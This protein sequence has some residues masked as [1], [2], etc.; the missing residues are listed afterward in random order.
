MNKCAALILFFLSAFAMAEKTAKVPLTYATDNQNDIVLRGQ[1]QTVSVPISI[2]DGQEVDS[3]RLSLSIY[4][5]NVIDKSMLWIS[6]GNRTL[7]NVEIK[8][9]AQHQL[10]EMTI[11][12]ELLSKREPRL[13]LR[14]QHLSNDPSLVIDTTRLKTII[15]AERSSYTLNYQES[16]QVS[17]AT[18]S[19]FDEM[20]RSGQH[21]DAPVHLVSVLKND[22]EAA[23]NIAAS[24]V[25][26][27]TLK[28]GSKEYHFDYRQFSEYNAALEGPAIVF[29]T[30]DDL[31][32]AGW[33]G[34]E[35]YQQIVGP[36]LGM[37]DTAKTSEWVLFLSGVSERDV[38][39]ATKVFA[40]NVRRLPERDH[41][42]VTE[43]DD[44]ID[45]SLKS[46]S[47]YLLSE[48]TDQ[49]DLT[50][51]P[52]E[53]S[54]VMP[55]NI[56]FSSE[57][58]AKINLLLTHSRVA[59]GAGS[60]ILRVNGDYANSLPLRS[61][62]WRDSQHYRLNIPMRDFRPGINKVT[63]EVYGPVDVRNQQ[64]RFAVYMSEKSNLKLSSWV[65][66]IPT[67]SH[68][69]SPQDFYAIS[70]D[71]GKKAQLTVDPNDPVQ[72]ESLWRLI[73]H[74]SHHTKKAMPGLL[75]TADREQTRPFH[76]VFGEEEQATPFFT[77]IKPHSTWGEMKQRLF[78]FV[79]NTQFEEE[80]V[81]DFEPNTVDE[82]A[83]VKHTND[84]GWYRIIMLEST[85]EEF[86]SFLRNEHIM[87]P[88]GVLSEREF[89]SSTSQFVKAAFIGYPA[90]LAA[91]ALLIIWWMS[92]FVTRS[93]ETRR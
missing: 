46:D 60:M 85:S 48:F 87:P 25:Q 86:A 30:R 89:S 55:S 1:S 35:Q 6:A 62:Y 81:N 69:V 44:M 12:S 19:S 90:G 82:I 41:W 29:G 9:R 93:L 50:D 16:G 58:N 24:L 27:W 66:F 74:V 61:S 84:Q 49:S 7:A 37:A 57:D 64:R 39:R 14:I 79:A 72:L 34:Q 26:G 36:Y 77:E 56:L 92:A 11:P 13:D 5:N 54:L 76:V 43:D 73:S 4:N 88:A 91:V 31:L 38:K 28:A 21:H 2:L 51:T 10:V 42:V 33:I 53:L 67:E 63:V 52:L 47:T 78:D 18:I 3:I 65:K 15:S 8:Q 75:V 80:S 32:S 17:N 71:C 22:P 45:R 59:P 70:D 68:H 23:L 40:N 83:Y 20:V